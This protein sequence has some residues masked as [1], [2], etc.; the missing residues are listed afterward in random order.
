M[1]DSENQTYIKKRHRAGKVWRLLRIQYLAHRPELWQHLPVIKNPDFPNCLGGSQEFRAWLEWK[2]K[3]NFPI[4]QAMKA[5]GM[6]A[7][8][9]GTYV[10]NVPGLLEKARQ[11]VNNNVQHKKRLDEPQQNQVNSQP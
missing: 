10:V 6:L 2:R 11:L 5:D 3:F 9:T 1:L 4:T 8:T 7:P